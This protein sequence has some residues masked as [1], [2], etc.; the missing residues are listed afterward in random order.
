M[1]FARV[2]ELQCK[3]LLDDSTL[4]EVVGLF[5]ERKFGQVARLLDQVQHNTFTE[6][7]FPIEAWISRAPD[8]F[9][10]A[11][12]DWKGNMQFVLDRS[13][14]ELQAAIHRMEG[15]LAAQHGSHLQQDGLRFFLDYSRAVLA[16]RLG[17]TGSVRQAEHWT[18]QVSAA[19][20]RAFPSWR[21][22]IEFVCAQPFPQLVAGAWKMRREE[23]SLRLELAA[24][25]A[26][27]M[28]V[29][30]GVGVG[31]GMVECSLEDREYLES[32]QF[33]LRMTLALLDSYPSPSSYEAWLPL[34]P[35]S[36]H[37]LF[38]DWKENLQFIYQQS[39][40]ALLS[41]LENMNQQLN[42]VKEEGRTSDAE[43]ID[44]FCSVIKYRLMY[45]PSALSKADSDVEPGVEA[46]PHPNQSRLEYWIRRIPRCVR[47]EFPDCEQNIRFLFL[48]PLESVSRAQ[49]RMKSERS[50]SIV[51][52]LVDYAE[53]LLFFEQV[54]QERI[55]QLS[56]DKDKAES[57]D[58]Q[59]GSRPD[60]ALDLQPDSVSGIDFNLIETLQSRI[61]S[62]VNH[63]VSCTPSNMDRYFE[64]FE[65][66]TV[67]IFWEHS[68]RDIFPAVSAVFSERSR[69]SSQVK[70]E[71]EEV[72][73]LR[74]L[75]RSLLSAA[76]TILSCFM[77]L[78]KVEPDGSSDLHES[79]SANVRASDVGRFID[80]LV[81]QLSEIDLL[82]SFTCSRLTQ[83]DLA[84][85][86]HSIEHSAASK[87]VTL[88]FAHAQT[89]SVSLQQPLPSCNVLQ[90]VIDDH[91][92]QSIEP[93]LTEEVVVLIEEPNHQVE[94]VSESVESSVAAMDVSAVPVGMQGIDVPSVAHLDT[95]FP[96]TSDGS[97]KPSLFQQTILAHM[98][99][100]RKQLQHRTGLAVMA[101]ALGKT[102]LA[103]LDI[104]REIEQMFVEPVA[105]VA[106][107]DSKTVESIPMATQKPVR[108]RLGL[109]GRRPLQRTLV[110]SSS[111][112]ATGVTSSRVE[113]DDELAGP[114]K[115]QKTTAETSS[116]GPHVVLSP[117]KPKVFASSKS[118]TDVADVA[119]V[120]Q[121]TVA[122]QQWT[123][124]CRI[125]SS[126]PVQAEVDSSLNAAADPSFRFLFLVHTRAIRDTA[127]VKFRRHFTSESTQR[128]FSASNF[129]NVESGVDCTGSILDSVRFV[130]CLFQSFDRLPPAFAST[131]TH[132]V[133]DEAHHL[134]AVTYR[135]IFNSLIELKSLRYMLGMTATLFHRD[136]PNGV[137]LRKLFRD[138]VYIDFPWTIA[139][140]LNHFPRVEYLEA[141]PT[142]TNGKDI[143]TYAQLLHSFADV[144]SSFHGNMSRFLKQLDSSLTKLAMATSEQVKK[145]LSP[146]YVAATF[147]SFQRTQRSAGLTASQK[148]IIFVSST[149]EADEITALLKRA[150]VSAVTAHYKMGSTAAQRNLDEFANGSATVL[151]TVMMLNEG[152]DVARVDCVV[153]ARLTESEIIFVQQMGR[154]LRRDPSCPDKTVVVLDLA[155][156]LRRRWK[157]LRQETTDEVLK[158]FITSFWHVGNFLGDMETIS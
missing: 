18:E 129:F 29:A 8:G 46:V 106:T 40:T 131:V 77:D 78:F 62:T 126:I 125:H 66:A 68:L 133:I 55:Q 20:R 101:T 97:F 146:Q 17:E 61:N 137:E 152:Y 69:L 118:T 99:W 42:Q 53:A 19:V 111:S 54:C 87:V 110:M 153:M 35:P 155:L 158:Q 96:V 5:R 51:K 10:A 25:A 128:R 36:V 149:K 114:V 98:E 105:T 67:R 4:A 82:G 1:S 21:Q 150:A 38:A 45:G 75:E 80:S 16:W 71:P 117:V 90:K 151:V 74:Y 123:C 95:V 48:Q 52:G 73:C 109:S 94:P 119:K 147:L 37:T 142:L 2:L 12:A 120:K 86:L 6:R 43:A 41:A 30:V 92:Q 91:V 154:G 14:A 88:L 104:H 11:F 49:Q 57:A 143:P 76:F 102:I 156:N 58:S 7:S 81:N 100:Q 113:S 27:G 107:T 31:G 115:R 65:A 3:G 124:L 141:L 60:S 140:S 130:F 23:E 64:D 135:Q 56:L 63:W 83:S 13:A 136:D 145:V 139:K 85:D 157:R 108:K 138:V 24:A 93:D 22:N 59:P 9:T 148:T 15:E 144:S 50:Q 122:W 34:A 112:T 32:L 84:T 33:F 47:N 121:S 132:V 127:F 72:Q 44:F 28:G 116:T 70:C 26:A 39:A 79:L 89:L 103:I 134:L